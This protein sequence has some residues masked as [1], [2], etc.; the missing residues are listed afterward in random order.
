VS[1]FGPHKPGAACLGFA[2]S[3]R[4]FTPEIARISFVWMAGSRERDQRPAAV[5]R[6]FASSTSSRSIR[7][8]NFMIEIAPEH[9]GG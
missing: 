9:R 2:A 5:R 8:A 6:G 3:R 1:D 7:S 4:V